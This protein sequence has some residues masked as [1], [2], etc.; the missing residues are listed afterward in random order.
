[1]GTYADA[2]SGLTPKVAMSCAIGNA[3]QCPALKE[4]FDLA[5]DIE[6]ST[7][8]KAKAWLTKMKIPI[9]KRLETLEAKMNNPLEVTIQWEFSTGESETLVF[10]WNKLIKCSGVSW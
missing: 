7:L 8:E 2:N 3:P 10:T 9:R 4:E 1:M 5:E 6:F